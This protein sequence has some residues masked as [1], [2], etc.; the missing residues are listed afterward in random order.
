MINVM[1]KL[2]NSWNACSIVAGMWKVFRNCSSV[3]LLKW[4]S[5]KHTSVMSKFLSKEPTASQRS[6]AVPLAPVLAPGASMCE[7]KS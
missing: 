5:W 6:V 2:D 7:C 1:I 3:A 4:Q